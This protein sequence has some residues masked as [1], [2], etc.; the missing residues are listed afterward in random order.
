MPHFR[1][2]PTPEIKIAKREHSLRVTEYREGRHRARR[3][4]IL[5]ARGKEILLSRFGLGPEARLTLADIE[6]HCATVRSAFKDNFCFLSGNCQRLRIDQ[7]KSHW[8]KIYKSECPDHILSSLL[9]DDIPQQEVPAAQ[10]DLP[11]AP[12]PED[13]LTELLLDE[14]RKL[15]EIK[16]KWHDEDDKTLVKVNVRFVE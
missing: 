16:T 13:E 8:V 3:N 1:Y 6:R 10:Q 5:R 9:R 4:S 15:P 11:E 2:Y 12:Q 14:V 7:Y